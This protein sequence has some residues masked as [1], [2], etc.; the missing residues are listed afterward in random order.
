MTSPGEVEGV[1]DE[2]TSG[3]CR[4]H[5]GKKSGLKFEGKV[6]LIGNK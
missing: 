5:L 1:I 4:E 6:E 3:G 2:G